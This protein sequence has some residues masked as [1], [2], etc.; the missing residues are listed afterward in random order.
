M[1]CSF[2]TA[3][4]TCAASATA[5]VTR[6]TFIPNTNSTASGDCVRY[7]ATRQCGIGGDR[8]LQCINYNALCTVGYGSSYNATDAAANHDSC[9]DKADGDACTAVWTCC[10]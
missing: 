10:P 3:A 5:L 4:L 7:S 1:R 9:S 6:S 8:V 2:F